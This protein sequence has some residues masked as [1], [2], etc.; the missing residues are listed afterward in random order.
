MWKIQFIQEFRVM[1]TKRKVL[2][3]GISLLFASRN[4]HIFFYQRPCKGGCQKLSGVFFLP[5]GLEGRKNEHLTVR[6]TVSVSPP[7][8]PPLKMHFWDPSQWH[9][10]CV[11]YHRVIFHWKN[12][13]KFSHLLTVRADGADLQALALL[14]VYSRCQS[15]RLVPLHGSAQDMP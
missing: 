13:S 11:E 10:M 3:F 9:K 15:S 5:R 4:A 8:P 2:P 6:L 12:G 7:P 14:W 1:G